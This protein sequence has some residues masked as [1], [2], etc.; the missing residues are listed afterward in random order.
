VI[1]LLY[2]TTYELVGRWSYTDLLGDLAR[3]NGTEV[4]TRVALWL[5]LFAGAVVGG[6]TQRGPRPIGPLTPHVVRCLAGGTV[7][8]LG[9][10][11]T[12]SAFDGLTFVGQPLLL[13]LAWTAMAATYTAITIGVMMLRSPRGARIRALRGTR[14]MPAEMFSGR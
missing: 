9:F 6:R 12:H 14:E 2:V 3:G 1:A 7:M 5:A 10:S 13:P 4:A 11:L 8:G